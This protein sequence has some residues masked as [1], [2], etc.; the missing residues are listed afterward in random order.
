M[1]NPHEP[2]RERLNAANRRP[3]RDADDAAAT[4]NVTGRDECPGY[5]EIAMS[6]PILLRS[7][8][9]A[10]FVGAVLCLINHGACLMNDKFNKMC[11]IQAVATAF[12]PFL[13][14]LVSSV[15][16]LRKEALNR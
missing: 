13:V 5:L 1:S 9:I 6:R 11:F 12:V 2:S 3:R 7:L 16:A 10:L 14:S 8:V 4:G 15:Y